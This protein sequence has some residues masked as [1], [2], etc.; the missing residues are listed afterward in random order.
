MSIILITFLFYTRRFRE[1]V[2]LKERGHFLINIILILS[3]LKYK[4]N[5][6]ACSPKLLCVYY[7]NTADII[8]ST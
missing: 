1:E 6:P 3:T 5:D 7:N 8:S 2:G 4:L